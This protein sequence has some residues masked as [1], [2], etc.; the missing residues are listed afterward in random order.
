MARDS[1][2]KGFAVPVAALV[3][4]FSFPVFGEDI[5]LPPPNKDSRVSVVQALELRQSQREFSDREIPIDAPTSGRTR[6]G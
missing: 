1:L 5:K 4:G 2:L 6:R 3:A